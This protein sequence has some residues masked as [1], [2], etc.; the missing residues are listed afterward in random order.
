M[1][2]VRDPKAVS[3]NFWKNS[4]KQVICKNDCRIQVPSSFF[5]NGLGSLG[6]DTR[7]YG[8]FAVILETGQ[9]SVVNTTAMFSI[10]P[11]STTIKTVSGVEYHEF[12]F[13]KDSVI[14]KTTGLL[15]QSKIIYNPFHTFLFMARVPWYVGYEDHGRL[16]DTAAKFAGFN[17]FSN[18]ETMEFLTAMI[19]RRANDL[20]NE[21]L[22]ISI[23]DY[24]EGD[25]G[26]VD[27]VPLG[28]V[29]TSVQ[30]PL[31]KISGAYAQDGIISA[32]VSP[33]DKVGTVEKLV[34]A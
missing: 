23:K 5:E 26:S 13:A 28:S 1:E 2:L 8:C 29:V 3:A 6:S 24:S 31:N 34:R 22:R 20:K 4:A 12:F 17:A 15:S 9:Y 27:F 33:S 32:I 11:T 10:N 16:F 30:S 21:F 19:A 14:F 7:I 18:P 25:P